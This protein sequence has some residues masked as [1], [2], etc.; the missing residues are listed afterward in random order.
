MI[1][2]I[3][4][5]ADEQPIEP[6]APAYNRS[7]AGHTIGILE[8]TESG[9]TGKFRSAPGREAKP[10][11]SKVD[12]SGRIDK[13]RSDDEIDTTS[14]TSAEL[15]KR[16]PAKKADSLGKDDVGVARS[17]VSIHVGETPAG[18]EVSW[19]PNHPN[20]PLNN[21]GFLVT[22]DS[23]TGKTQV[24]RALVAAVCDD[25]L[26][27][28]VFDFKN[29]YAESSFAGKH[30]LRVHD[31]NRHGLPFNP[32]SLLGDETGEVQ[33][34]RQVHELS[35]ILQRIYKLSAARQAARLRAAMSA[36]YENHGIRVDAWQKIKDIKSFPDFNEVKQIIEDDERN[37]GLL[38]RLSPLFDLNLFPGS[39]KTSATFD[40][41][42]RE[43]VVLDMHKLPNDMV[44]SALSEFTVVRLHGHILKG[45]QPRELRRLLVFDEAW[46]VKDSERLQELAREGRAFGVGVVVGTQFPGDIPED[47]AGNLATQLMLSNQ[48]AD[49]RKSFT[50][51]SIYLVSIE[52]TRKTPKKSWTIVMDDLNPGIPKTLTEYTVVFSALTRPK[53]MKA[54]GSPE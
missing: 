2:K 50:A 37:D 4:I 42:M 10:S 19:T 30:G 32:L 25:G 38:D 45:D 1:F 36:A 20:T 44:K 15:T 53:F 11:S 13:T 6:A 7:E 23:G 27:V 28:C 31:V 29:D 52:V 43:A 12:S 47:L 48:S 18:T 21:F 26:P 24:I 35:G 34:I 39:E 40:E 33:P 46:R 5:A 16:T 22:G 49:H 8:L 54:I 14:K 17:P 3:K 9:T 41:F 51:S